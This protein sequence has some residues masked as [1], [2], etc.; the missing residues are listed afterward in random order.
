MNMP[1]GID[2]VNP[3]P[4]FFGEN[5]TIAIK[6]GSISE[7]RL[8]DMARRIMTPYYH[9]N[10]NET[11]AAIDGASEI[12][13]FYP[14][15]FAYNFTTGPANVD[16]RADHAHL[17]REI[18]SAG[19][20]LLKN[21]DNVLPLQR[22]STLGV[23]G[24]AAAPLLSGS[25]VSPDFGTLPVGGGSGTGGLQPPISPYEAIRARATVDGTFVQSI[26]NDSILISPPFYEIAGLTLATGLGTI[27]PRPEVCLV[28]VKLYNA[29]GADLTSLEADHSADKI[30]EEVS[31]YCNRTVVV[32][33]T[34]GLI[35]MPWASNPNVTAI[36]AAHLPGEQIGNSIVDVLYGDYN[37]SGK[38]PYTVAYN[39]SDY[40][41][42]PIANS[43]ALIESTNATAWVSD[44]NEGLLIDYKHFDYYNQSVQYEF[45][46]GLSYTTFA[47]SN[48]SITRLARSSNISSASSGPSEP[49]GR[50]DLYE[51]LYNVGA[52]VHNTGDLAGSAVS[53]LYIG[54][55]PITGSIPTPK[56]V[57]RG[58]EKTE[59]AP[60]QSAYVMFPV[61]RKDISFWSVESQNWIIPSESLEFAVGFSSRDIKFTEEVTVC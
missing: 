26:L 32:T 50:I 28:F 58:F 29:E 6:N 39:Q 33:N 49:G 10:Q 40:D 38:L 41:Y 60:G 52:T 59:L 20:V 23:F 31:S 34:A 16:V 48:V 2:L 51:V 57:L 37:P 30:V 18:G 43:T 53:Q 24:S 4:T 36:L 42:A 17:I 3:V 21:N 55:P 7:A 25:A 11:V 44:F 19:M 22:P 9:L 47:L 5:I 56:R 14:Q 46:F 54:M 13:G 27:L 12:L 15:P 45:G 61:R 35:V 1:G 8:D